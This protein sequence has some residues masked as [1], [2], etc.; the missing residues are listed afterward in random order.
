MQN[1]KIFYDSELAVPVYIHASDHRLSR[2]DINTLKNL[3]VHVAIDSF[4]KVIFVH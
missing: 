1:E 3:S 4:V 2:L